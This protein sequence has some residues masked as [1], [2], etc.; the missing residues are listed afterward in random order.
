MLNQQRCIVLQERL[1]Q[2]VAGYLLDYNSLAGRQDVSEEYKLNLQHN[3]QDAISL[4][5]KLTTGIDVN[6][7]FHDIRGFEVRLGSPCGTFCL[8]HPAPRSQTRLNVCECSATSH[9]D[10]PSESRRSAG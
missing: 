6:I 5:P 9:I 2:L 4:L 7:R 1:V 10:E 3:V 8:G